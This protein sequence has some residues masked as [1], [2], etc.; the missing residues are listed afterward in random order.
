MK[1]LIIGLSIAIVVFG[2]VAACDT[3]S[4][5]HRGE[6][7][8]GHEDPGEM[9]AAAKQL[10]VSVE[11]LR[12]ALGT[13]PPDIKAAAQKLGVSELQLNQALGKPSKG[14]D[15]EKPASG[16]PPPKGPDRER[17]APGGPLT[18]FEKAAESLGI[19]LQVVRDALGGPP[20]DIEAAAQKLGISESALTEALGR[21]SA[22][23]GVGGNGGGGRVEDRYACVIGPNGYCIFTGRP[24]ETGLKQGIDEV[25]DRNGNFL[26]PMNKAVAASSSGE[27]LK[28]TGRP[29]FDGDDLIESSQDGMTDDEKAFHRVMAIMFPIRNALMY[30]IA[31]ISQATWDELISELKIRGIKD[32]TF[33]DGAT[34]RDNYYGRQV[35]FELT[36]NPNGKDIHH[37]VMKFL[38]EAGL[39]LLCHVTSDD[40]SQMLKDT[41]PEGHDPCKDAGITS[42]I[43]FST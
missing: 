31:D 22:K 3:N 7:G 29:A 30:D 9:E 28:A 5:G 41:H 33:T 18:G 11:V 34:P 14:H 21:P 23:T 15:R 12:Y 4:E 17:P 13:P 42:K 10:G 39:Y 1:Q 8:T 26:F 38:E 2:L 37:D 27:V 20:P 25:L 6:D 32:K 40:F 36:K 35:I 24:H 43:P 19:P 16:G